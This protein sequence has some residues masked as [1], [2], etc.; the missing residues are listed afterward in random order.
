LFQEGKHAEAL[1]TAEAWQIH[2]SPLGPVGYGSGGVYEL[3]KNLCP[4]RRLIG[5]RFD[6]SLL[7]S[8][9]R[10][11]GLLTGDG[12]PRLQVWTRDG[13]RM[14]C[15]QAVLPPGYLLGSTGRLIPQGGGY[16]LCAG[17]LTWVRA[18]PGGPAWRFGFGDGPGRGLPKMPFAHTSLFGR[19][20]LYNNLL[21][22]TCRDGGI[23]VFDVNA[24]T[25][26][27]SVPPVRPDAGLGPGVSGPGGHPVQ[28]A[29][30]LHLSCAAVP[31]RP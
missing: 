7:A 4:V 12:V 10:T 5:G 27:V 11:L 16:L 3:D 28:S 23:Y 30:T 8:D 20:L 29:L 14:L 18:A 17:E 13:K 6:V 22:V 2:L 26:P 9:S 21:F 24:V 25:R 15:Q 1:A 19:P 31:P